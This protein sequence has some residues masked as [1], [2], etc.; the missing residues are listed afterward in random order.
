[1]GGNLWGIPRWEKQEPGRKFPPHWANSQVQIGMPHSD[2]YRRRNFYEIAATES[3]S[4]ANNEDP[5]TPA[6]GPK[7]LAMILQSS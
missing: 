1:M 6:E 2:H 5:I 4:R 3:L 7:A